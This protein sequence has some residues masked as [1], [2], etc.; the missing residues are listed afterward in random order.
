MKIE[1]HNRQ[2]AVRVPLA[3]LRRIATVALARCTRAGGDGPAVLRELHAVEVTLV[4]D[5][6]SA[7]VHARFMGIAGP[8]DVIT[9]EHGEIVISAATAARQ[10]AE[11]GAVLAEELALYIIHGLLHL[12]GYE[13]KTARGAARMRR[14]QARLLR[15]C[16]E[17]VPVP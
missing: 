9:F 13:D 4:S 17:R 2:R 12:N 7:V 11:H 10:A 3:W 16:L 15:A 1:V 5:R 8:T 6:L 14:V